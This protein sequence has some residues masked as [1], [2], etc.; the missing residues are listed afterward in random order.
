LVNLLADQGRID[1]LRQRAESGN[2]YAGSRLA[3]ILIEQGHIDEAGTIL[4]RCADAGDDD[5]ALRLVDLLVEQGHIDELRQ[6]ADAEIA[7]VA[8]RLGDILGGIGYAASRLAAILVEQ[9]HIDELRQRADG[10]DVHA[11]DKLTDLL[12]EQGHID[13]ASTIL[14]Q[15]SDAGDEDMAYRLVHLLA[16]HGHINELRAEVHAGTPSAAEI[17]ADLRVPADLQG[18]AC[19]PAPV[20]KP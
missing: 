16:D 7:H 5:A 3:G 6:R 8:Y 20:R 9:G 11:I 4:R 2:T 12:V 1:E 13:E 19:S 17:L 15:R 14:R 18:N 10:G